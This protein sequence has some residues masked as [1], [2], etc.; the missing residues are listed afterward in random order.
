MIPDDSSPSGP[1]ELPR[2]THHQRRVFAVLT[3]EWKTVGQIIIDTGTT[4]PTARGSAGRIANE[5]VK[6]D[7][8]E[9]G[10]SYH[11]PV[12]R[13]SAILRNLVR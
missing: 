8:A 12:L 1:T 11:R 2:L 13:Q 4:S 10:G 9:K 6:L 3:T 5:L 7:L